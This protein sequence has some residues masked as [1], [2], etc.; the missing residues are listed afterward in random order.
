MASH[1]KFI[2]TMLAL[3]ALPWL[4]ACNGQIAHAANPAVTTIA[5]STNAPTQSASAPAA[6]AAPPTPVCTD[7]TLTPSQTEG[8]YF[9]PGSPERAS[10]L[11]PGITGMNLIVT[12]YVLTTDCKPVVHALLDFWQANAQG[13]YNNTGYTLRGH[14]FTDAIGR[15]Q[16]TTIVPGL[17][18]GRTEHIHV[19]VQ[20]PNGSILTTQL[21][22]PD[23]SDNQ[24]DG[25]FDSQLLLAIQNTSDGV[26][27]TFNFVVNAP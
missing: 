3:A 15:Y 12:G 14:L 6:Q 18:P 25:I 9:K 17:Y 16:L 27:G 2:L 10:L 20:P 13:Q 5:P 7:L 1:T 4:A 8:P 23:V 24:R 21:Y 22:F 26:V 11:Q 19:K